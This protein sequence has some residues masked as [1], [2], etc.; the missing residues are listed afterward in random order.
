MDTSLAV[1]IERM[2][3]IVFGP[4]QA[5]AFLSR[6]SLDTQEGAQRLALAVLQARG[7]L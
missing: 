7:V 3:I 4:V 5:R 1:Q 2:A 6:F